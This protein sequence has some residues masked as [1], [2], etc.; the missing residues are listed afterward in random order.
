MPS[1]QSPNI[2]LNRLLLSASIAVSIAVSIAPHAQATDAQANGHPHDYIKALGGAVATSQSHAF[3]FSIG[4]IIQAH[5]EWHWLP[6]YKWADLTDHPHSLAER[7]WEAASG[8][9]GP[10]A[11]ILALH[12]LSTRVGMLFQLLSAKKGEDVADFTQRMGTAIGDYSTSTSASELIWKLAANNTDLLYSRDFLKDSTFNQYVFWLL[13]RT[14]AYAPMLKKTIPEAL[15]QHVLNAVG[16]TGIAFETSSLNDHF[17]LTFVTSSSSD[18]PGNPSSAYL[19]LDLIKRKN[20]FSDPE[21]RFELALAK[22]Q[23]TAHEHNITRIRFYPAILEEQNEQKLALFIRPYIDNQ[24]GSLIRFP[25]DF[26]TANN[27][28]WWTDAMDKGTLHSINNSDEYT[29]VKWLKN[30]VAG[31]GKKSLINPF[32]DR[33]LEKLPALLKSASSIPL[34]NDYGYD[35]AQ[36]I[37]TAFEPEA[38]TLTIDDSGDFGLS[39]SPKQ[40]SNHTLIN[41]G[42]SAFIFSDAYYS[43]QL[44]LPI[45]TLITRKSFNDIKTEDVQKLEHHLP[46]QNYHGAAK[47]AI[48][49]IKNQAYIRLTNNLMT[50]R[51]DEL[52]KHYEK[53]KFDNYSGEVTL[54]AIR[55]T[56]VSTDSA[57]TEFD[58]LNFRC[59]AHRLCQTQLTN[60]KKEHIGLR[61]VATKT[62]KEAKDAEDAVKALKTK[63]AAE[64]AAPS[65]PALLSSVFSKS[66]LR[67]AKHEATETSEKA[68]AAAAALTKNENSI[69]EQTAQLVKFKKDLET[70]VLEDQIIS[71]MFLKSEL[72]KHD[73]NSEEDAIPKDQIK[74]IAKIL[75]ISDGYGITTAF[76]EIVSSFRGIL[77]SLTTLK[78]KFF[79]SKPS[80]ESKNDD[81]DSGGDRDSG[82]D[83]DGDR[84][85]GDDRDGDRDGDRDR[86]DDRDGDRDSGDDRDGDRDRGDDGDGDENRHVDKVK[87]AV[88][89][90]VDLRSQAR[91]A[92]SAEER[93]KS[94]DK[95][96]NILPENDQA[97]NEGG[98]NAGSD[99]AG[100]RRQSKRDKASPSSILTRQPLT[101]RA[102]AA[103]ST[104]PLTVNK[105]N[106]KRVQFA[107]EPAAAEPATICGSCGHQASVSEATVD[108]ASATTAGASKV[109]AAGSATTAGASETAATG[110]A[111]TADASET[112][113]A[114]SATDA[115]DSATA[116]AGS[117]TTAGD[118]KVAAASPGDARERMKQPPTK[119]D[120]IRDAPR[121]RTK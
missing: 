64:E 58:T 86:G 110:S 8:E 94:A 59:H 48:T 27:Q 37:H 22:L 57:S 63:E 70:L 50:A 69:K 76:K 14:L 9:I 60:I 103:D 32:S 46:W 51:S 95:R 62:A 53:V 88:N 54:K 20:L 7:T 52:N 39:G 2:A 116:S 55:D 11:T 119:P 87:V 102:A 24:A 12:C 93:A 80:E 21:G 42:D 13:K 79:P 68:E 33:I 65:D 28:I 105:E 1:M 29:A 90:L 31:K 101:R 17:A 6:G 106:Q 23:K 4:N 73:E 5:P 74:E 35:F 43:Q 104:A 85:R 38:N 117:A 100:T 96:K 36:Q 107:A 3:S 56:D 19:D 71:T 111:T 109:A 84:D 16:F 49:V 121:E 25:V 78:T 113:A 83:R 118:S 112:A 30:K 72:A 99:S 34:S 40:S 45:L 26:G 98:D 91:G 44:D 18:D 82:D 41:A 47:I 89:T 120:I 15:R 67:T 75:G 81:G 92:N 115:A 114:G 77:P 66:A 108:D 61:D 10:I 97:Q